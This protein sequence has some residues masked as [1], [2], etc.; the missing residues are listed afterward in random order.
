MLAPVIEAPQFFPGLLIGQERLRGPVS[1]AQ[2][3]PGPEG[4]VVKGAGFDNF[5]E[6]FLC[7]PVVSPVSRD[8]SHPEEGIEV[9]GPLRDSPLKI[10][11]E[12]LG[13]L[14][15]LFAVSPV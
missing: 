6:I 9:I 12:G 2:V 14:P 4:I 5:F 11:Q 8:A 1:H 7:P 13:S 15:A 3:H 10:L